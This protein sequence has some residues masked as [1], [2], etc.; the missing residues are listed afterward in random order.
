MKRRDIIAALG[1]GTVA[2]LAGCVTE[3]EPSDSGD[4]PDEGPGSDGT[5]PDGPEG[6]GGDDTDGDGGGDSD[7]DGDRPGERHYR[8][9]SPA[10]E[11]PRPVQHG[12]AVTQPDIHSPDV[13]LTLEVTLENPTERTVRYGERREALCSY[14]RDQGF[15]LLPSESREPRYDDETGVW[16]VD[17][18]IAVTEE[19]QM[20]EL[21]PGVAHSQELVLVHEDPDP[22]APRAVPAQFD[23]AAS[24]GTETDPDVIPDGSEYTFHFS[25]VAE[26]AEDGTT[27]ADV[28]CSPYPTGREWAAC[29][30]PAAESVAGV[31]M[32]VDPPST[33]LV[34]GLP[35]DEVSLTVVNDSDSDLTFNP[36]SWRIRR[37]EQ[38][39]WSDVDGGMSGDGMVSVDAGESQ[40]WT[41]TEAVEAVQPDP[42]LEPGL[43]TAE[44]GVPHPDA[45]DEWIACI[46]FIRLG[47]AD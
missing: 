36:Y 34:D 39:N 23:F 25:L 18:P 44:I 5:D 10:L 37:Y 33:T 24:F 19:F 9:I 14:L 13:P 45:D 15:V 35:A 7:R 8:A 40:S 26:G 42:D 3:R 27:P 17:G 31:S 41:F 16:Y 32:S 6:D 4:D 1:T 20:G 43:Y 28:A 12:I 38:G 30:E 47:A 11:T 46:A 29:S 2:G 22:P 21:E